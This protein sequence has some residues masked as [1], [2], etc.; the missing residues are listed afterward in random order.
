MSPGLHSATIAAS[1]PSC[2]PPSQ[3]PGFLSLDQENVCADH[4]AVFP[5]EHRRLS[6]LFPIVFPHLLERSCS[7]HA[8]HDFDGTRF[9]GFGSSGV[10]PRGLRGFR[11]LGSIAAGPIISLSCSARSS[12][13]C[14]HCFRDSLL[15]H[16]Q[17]RAKSTA[18]SL[19]LIGPPLGPQRFDSRRHTPRQHS[20]PQRRKRGL[21]FS[22]VS[23]REPSR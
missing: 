14:A 4:L 12:A 3:Y 13:K 16:P 22:H 15:T 1:H 2:P 9:H 21:H 17:M 18:L 6:L 10:P 20:T 8:D 5:A 19:R 23:G 7:F 11:S